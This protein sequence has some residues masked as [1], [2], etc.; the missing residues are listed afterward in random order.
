MYSSFFWCTVHSHFRHLPPFSLL[1]VVVLFSGPS[2]LPSTSGCHGHV[3]N[4]VV[5]YSGARSAAVK[6]YPF[7]QLSLDVIKLGQ[8]RVP[9]YLQNQFCQVKYDISFSWNFLLILEARS[10]CCKSQD[11]LS[12][13]TQNTDTR[14]KWSCGG[15]NARLWSVIY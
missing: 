6:S 10:Y 7:R 2:C 14:V 3:Q 9:S 5:E 1:Y 13:R 4:F 11:L 15:E 12:L 8:V